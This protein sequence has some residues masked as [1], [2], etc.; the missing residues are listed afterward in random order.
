MSGGTWL[1]S[2]KQSSSL[3]WK[4][5]E[6]CE[7]SIEK[8]KNLQIQSNNSDSRKSAAQKQCLSHNV[9]NLIVL[10]S[11]LSAVQKV[12]PFPPVWGM[13]AKTAKSLRGTGAI[14]H[15]IRRVNQKHKGI[16]FK[17]RNSH[18]NV[19]PVSIGRCHWAPRNRAA[20]RHKG[21]KTQNGMTCYHQ[22]HNNLCLDGEKGLKWQRVKGK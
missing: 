16:F 8:K 4:C 7:G 3:Y 17:T 11:K 14:L 10:R 2:T 19:T 5:V 20:D 12:I 15:S 21:S 18:N 1:S 9:L 13:K 6:H 22:L